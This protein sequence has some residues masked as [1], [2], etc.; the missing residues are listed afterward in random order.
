[1]ADVAQYCPAGFESVTYN[2]SQILFNTQ[3]A[4]MFIDGS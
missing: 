4:A 3:R 2:D 1:M